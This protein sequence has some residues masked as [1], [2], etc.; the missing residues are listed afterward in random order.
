MFFSTPSNI[1]QYDAEMLEKQYYEIQWQHKKEQQSLL[2]LQE[3]VEAH[4]I[5]HADQKARR[6]VEAKAKEEAEK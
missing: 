4:C 1:S 5:E 6:E 3:A 2:H